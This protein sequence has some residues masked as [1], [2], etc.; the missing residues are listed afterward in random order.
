VLTGNFAGIN[1]A[2]GPYFIKTETDL[3]GGSNYT[4]S[5]TQQL[6]SVPYALY[7]ATAGNNTPGPQGP[8]GPQGEVGPQGPQGNSATDNQQLSVS[9]I[10][11]TLFLQ[12][13]GF[14]IIP[15]ISGANDNNLLSGLANHT[16]GASNVHNPQ[17]S[18][19][20]VIDIDGNVY[21]TVVVNGIEWMTENLNTSRYQN[22]DTIPNI[23]G[24]WQNNLIGSWCY[25]FDN[26]IYECPYGKL[27]NW[28]AVSDNRGLC[29]AGWQVPS[30]EEWTAFGW[31][32]NNAPDAIKSTGD[33]YWNGDN[34]NATN[35]FGFSALPAG[36][37][38]T[39]GFYYI[40]D[41]AHW[42]SRT[43]FNIAQAWQRS[44][45][46]Y[47]TLYYRST[48]DTKSGISV[49]CIRVN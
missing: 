25:Y 34:S 30:D 16:C 7:A 45:Q 3:N 29:P 8:A 24:S 48:N 41:V 49:R 46:D 21:K 17:I 5:A 37:K 40:G 6:F 18:Y 19:G 13:G 26:Q 22:G 42:W 47:G 35:G 1:W 32:F 12:G 20:Q 23:I 33:T 9:E 28:Y 15:G 2:N 10:G 43:Q 27:Y 38:G 11:D 14:V 4:I 44:L 31:Y 36:I 39:L